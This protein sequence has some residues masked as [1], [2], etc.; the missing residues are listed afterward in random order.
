MKYLD[1]LTETQKKFSRIK[2]SINRLEYKQALD[3]ILKVRE[4][5]RVRKVTKKKKSRKSKKSSP[6]NK[7]NSIKKNLAKLSPEERIKF[8]T[9]LKSMRG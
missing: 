6:K 8:L 2:P 5:R 9:E 7:V 3:I 1:N 4:S